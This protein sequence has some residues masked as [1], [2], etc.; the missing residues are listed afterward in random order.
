MMQ[1]HEDWLFYKNSSFPL[2]APVLVVNGTL[3][4]DGF[5]DE[6]RRLEPQILPSF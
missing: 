3:T 4:K 1:K 5:L 6:L 2:P